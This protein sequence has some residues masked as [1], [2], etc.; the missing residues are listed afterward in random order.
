MQIK[1]TDMSTLYSFQNVVSAFLTFI[2]NKQFNVHPDKCWD[3]YI[4]IVFVHLDFCTCFITILYHYT[5]LWKCLSA[6]L[7]YY[8]A[9]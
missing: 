2:L 9:R 6:Y 5:I 3:L 8:W 4:C 1:D 7:W